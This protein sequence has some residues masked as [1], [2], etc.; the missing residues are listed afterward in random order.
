MQKMIAITI[1]VKE[2]QGNAGEPFSIQEVEALNPIF[3]EGWTIENQEF[4]SVEGAE[5]A[6]LLV[7]LTDDYAGVEGGEEFH[8]D[9]YNAL[10]DSRDAE[11]ETL[12]EEDE[13][14]EY[15]DEKD[16]EAEEGGDEEQ[17]GDA[18]PTRVMMAHN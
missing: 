11:D 18:E 4:L 13:E 14:G 12:G 7:T 10:S 9:F 5:Q 1:N 17:E 8:D 3:E 15:E 6:V 16:E 2:L